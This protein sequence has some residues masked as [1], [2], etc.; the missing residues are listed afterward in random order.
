MH[1]NMSA[2]L[3]CLCSRVRRAARALTAHY[4]AALAGTGF[5]T[6]QFSL[7][8][9]LSRTGPL[10]MT[11]FSEATGHDRTTLSRTIKPLEAAGL[12]EAVGGVDQRTR[13]LALTQRGAAEI[14]RVLP[15]WC[16][17][18]AQTEAKLGADGPRLIALLEKVESL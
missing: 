14:E 17:A 18:Q 16:A 9:T 2:P 7:L 4:D 3:P 12:V 11:A 13:I 6:P 5:T 1:P 15:H 10:S 8:R